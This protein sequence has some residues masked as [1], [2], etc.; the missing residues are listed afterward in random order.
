MNDN[1]PGWDGRA[2]RAAGSLPVAWNLAI[3]IANGTGRPAYAIRHAQAS[4]GSLFVACSEPDGSGLPVAE[5]LRVP[6]GAEP[7]ADVLA[8]GAL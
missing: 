4:G 2:L 7:V 1:Q 8:G 6:P 3:A 5:C